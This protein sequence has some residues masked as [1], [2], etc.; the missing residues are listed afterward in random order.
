MYDVGTWHIVTELAA[1]TAGALFT[2]AVLGL[3]GRD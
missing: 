1:L 3:G 2:M